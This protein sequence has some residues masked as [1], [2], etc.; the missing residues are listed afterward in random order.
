LLPEAPTPAP[1]NSNNRKSEVDALAELERCQWLYLAGENKKKQPV[2][3]AII[4][5]LERSYFSEDL[6]DFVLAHIFK[7]MDVVASSQRYVVCVDMSYARLT[8]DM[9]KLLYQKLSDVKNRFAYAYH[10]N[11]SAIYVVHPTPFTRAMLFFMR[12]VVC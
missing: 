12:F 10:K 1:P 2:V 3:Y 4:N 5:R 6:I 9:R 11:L 8:Q 7:V